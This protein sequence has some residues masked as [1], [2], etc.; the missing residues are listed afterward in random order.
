MSLRCSLGP[1]ILYKNC[2]LKQ[3]PAIFDRLDAKIAQVTDQRQGSTPL[4][5]RD[6][7]DHVQFHPR[8][9][10]GAVL[11]EERL[12]EEIYRIEHPGGINYPIG[13]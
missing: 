4:S 12:L 3:N 9:K 8:Y 6:F 5:R 10:N 11:M 2:R 13:H 1:I 7:R